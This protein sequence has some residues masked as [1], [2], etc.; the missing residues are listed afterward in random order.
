ME[1]QCDHE[2]HAPKLTYG[3][4]KVVFCIY[5]LLSYDG[6][7]LFKFKKVVKSAIIATFSSHSVH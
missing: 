2:Y 7:V 6:F 1:I 4:N 3:H 5:L